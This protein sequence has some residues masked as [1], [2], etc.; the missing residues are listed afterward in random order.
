MVSPDDERIGR[1]LY[2]VAPFLH[3][4]HQHQQLPVP[5]LVVAFGRGETP[6][7]VLRCERTALT[8][9]SEASTS[10]IN[11]RAGSG[12]ESTGAV[13]NSI[14]MCAKAALALSVPSEG[15]ER[16]G[17]LH[18]LRRHLAVIPDNASVKI[19]KP[20]EVIG[21]LGVLQRYPGHFIQLMPQ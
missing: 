19:G 7:E 20:Q 11:C 14:L 3:H 15:A 16:G 2:P 1:P 17:E 6:T 9:V 5:H 13:V 21:A 10:T 8:P 4:H 12:W 18:Q